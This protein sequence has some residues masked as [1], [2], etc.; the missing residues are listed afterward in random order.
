MEVLKVDKVGVDQNF[1]DLG[2]HSML[3]AQVHLRLQTLLGRELALVD[4]FKYPTVSLL[5]R[6]INAEAREETTAGDIDARTEERKDKLKKQRQTRR[7][8]RSAV[9]GHKEEA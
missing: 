6:F 7:K 4:F 9:A 5:A 2:G 3:L 8:A 1:F